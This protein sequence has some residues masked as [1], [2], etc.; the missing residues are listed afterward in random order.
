MTRNTCKTRL[1]PAILGTALLL[2]TAAPA[3]SADSDSDGLS[4]AWET[5]Y[6]TNPY[7]SDGDGD[8]W[9]DYDEI[10][11][12]GTDPNSSDTDLD[13][14]ADNLDADPLLASGTTPD[15]VT[16]V[17]YAGLPVGTQQAAS[18][19]S[20]VDGV[21]VQ[22]HSGE[23]V[24]S[25]G[26]A[27]A[28]GVGLPFGLS[29]VYRSHSGAD[30]GFGMNWM[31]MLDMTYT[32]QG[33]GDVDVDMFDATTQ[34]FTWN[35]TG[36]DP[37]P[38]YGHLYFAE[39]TLGSGDYTL[40]FPGGFKVTYAS[41][42]LDKT[43]DRDGNKIDLIHNGS[44][45][46]TSVTDTR[47]ESHTVSYYTT[48]RVK[49]F[50]M[51]DGRKW[52]FEYNA[53]AQLAR[54]KGPATTSFPS[55]IWQEF[56]YTNG[57][58][59]PNLNDN[60]VKV[61]D[62]NGAAWLQMKYDT[63]DRVTEQTVGDGDFEFDWTNI[64][65]QKAS[66]TDRAGNDRDWEWH[67]TKLTRTKLTRFS[68]R[69]VRT[70]D[71]ASWVT[72]W[73]HDADGYLLTT[74][75]P[76]G[77]GTKVT[78]NS[79]KLPTEIRRKEDMTAS[80]GTGDL[81]TTIAYDSTKYWGRT[82]V[83]D[84][85][86]NATTYTLN[87]KGRPTTIS[88]PAST[89]VSPSQSI[90]ETIVWNTDGTMA[91]RTDGEGKKTSWT[92]YTTPASKK[93]RVKDVKVDDGGLDLVSSWD[94]TAWGDVT[95]STDPESHTTTYTVEAYGN[96]T[97]VVP[98]GS[99]GYE[100]LYEHDHN[101]NVTVR[102]VKNVDHTGTAGTSPTHFW[103]ETWYTT[104]DRPF[105]V[106]E[107]LHTAG[108]PVVQTDIT[109]DGND[110]V[111]EHVKGLVKHEMTY[112]ER[113]LLAER[114]GD[115]GTGKINATSTY[116]YDK[117]G[118]LTE[119]SDPRSKKTTHEYD[120][121]DRRTKTIDALDNYVVTTYDENGNVTEREWYEEDGVTDVLVAHS[122]GHFDELNRF[123]KEEAALIETTTTWLVRRLELDKRGLVTK[124]INRLN[125][126]TTYAY[127]GA[128]RRTSATDPSATRSSGRGTTAGR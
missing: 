41:G 101:L 73:T 10:Y 30:Y 46:V 42:V 77:N 26:V 61:Y 25:A 76:E 31:S 47:G 64:G 80:D 110:N 78:L 48:G 100:T 70:S 37:P 6:G 22:M 79:A 4:D 106:K 55:G 1:L 5:A 105:M 85:R 9:S 63:S 98:P 38:G 23:L 92:Y 108:S 32:V 62:G 112:D 115:P 94:Y 19:E 117:N 8:S 116:D 113:D 83:T 121:F 60:L 72:T 50:T 86:G 99:L 88:Y 7:S 56:R 45:Q 120:G 27:G 97:K 29:L 65:T 118:N 122:K 68:N 35:G 114:V 16:T 54:I 67:S 93:G 123:W 95:S 90:S 28:K 24:Y 51:S 57:S 128:G 102:K 20:P 96:V 104:M 3:L 127:D 81:V 111:T 17:T 13:G 12:H 36:Y 43:E 103:T 126:A 124:R 44:N 75:L 39:T 71:P 21:G 89:H 11:E 119:V 18:G 109:Y 52:T 14:T 125:D 91:S 53:N 2:L 87:S 69:D 84:P 107:H 66:V 82:S 59:D 34:T 15:G 49:D 40:T 33:N 58:T 74:T